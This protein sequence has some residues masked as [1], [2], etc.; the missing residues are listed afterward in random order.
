MLKNIKWVIK[1]V[2]IGIV[3]LYVV[4]FLGLDLNI[5]I[6]INIITILI[7]GFLR[8]PG[9]VILLILTKL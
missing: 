3:A 7:V 8:I 6:P 2:L 9:L 5:F 4:N 1:N